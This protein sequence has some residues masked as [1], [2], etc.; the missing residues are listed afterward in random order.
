M[1]LWTVIFKLLPP[2]EPV[3][4]KYGPIGMSL[5]SFFIISRKEIFYTT[6]H[7]LKILWKYTESKEYFK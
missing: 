4:L 3:S 2:V 6:S 7:L 5:C 1:Y